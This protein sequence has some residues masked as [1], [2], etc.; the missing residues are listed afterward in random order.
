MN[1][2]AIRAA[3]ERAAAGYDAAAFLQQEVARRLD[4]RLEV[5]KIEPARILDAGCGTG[6]AF[7]LLRAR[8]PQATLCGLDLAL[9]MLRQARVRQAAPAGW[10]KWL[11]TSKNLLRDPIAALRGARSLAYLLD[12]SRSLRSVRL[13]LVPLA[14]VFRGARLSPRPAPSNLVCADVERLPFKR[15]SLDLVW[16][17]LTLQWVG[18]LE[19]SFREVHRVLR[20]GGLFAFSTFG[21]DTLKELRQAF[22]GLDGFGHVN[23]FTD[24]HDIGDMLVHAGFAHPVMEMEYLTL[25]YADLK[26]L[27]R[28]LKAIGADTVLEGRRPGLM[29]RR[30]WQQVNENY[31]RLRRDGR[32]PAT[33]EVVYGHAWAGRKDHL[34]DGRQLIAFEIA[35]RRAKHGL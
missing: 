14:T 19:A 13:A 21:P 7:P 30:L 28:E 29:G 12:M 3:F 15:D 24:M 25:T 34:E 10:R 23:R 11:G 16:S 26:S 31:E 6:Y 18:D 32:L 20:P 1:K 9:G 2:R 5:M 35:R 17:N 4:E 27:L 33:F 8:Y 22:A